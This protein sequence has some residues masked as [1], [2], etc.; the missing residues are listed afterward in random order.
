[1]TPDEELALSIAEALAAAG[2]LP[3]NDIEDLKDALATKT[4]TEADWKSFLTPIFP[5][6]V[7][8][9]GNGNCLDRQK[10]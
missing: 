10:G 8:T 2:N 6:S 5:P 9:A 4:L 7:P 1:M 3:Q